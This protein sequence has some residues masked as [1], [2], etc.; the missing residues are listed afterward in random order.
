MARIFVSS[1]Y[2]DLKECREQICLILR[3]AGHE[4]L[5]MEY[6][7]TRENHLVDR[8]LSDVASSDLYVGIFAWRYG[9]IPQQDNPNQLSITELEY[10]QA[11]RA[12]KECL[13]FLLH[14]DAPW[15]RKYIDT[16]GR[17]DQ[18]R[19]EL[20]AN[21]RCAYFNSAQEISS[22]AGPAIHQWASQRGLVSSGLSIQE[23]DLETYY[24]ALRKRYQRLDLEGLTP[25]QKEE[26]LQ[27]QLRLVF[28][29]QSVREDPP[30]IELSKEVWEKLHRE[31]EIHREDF[32]I[33]MAIDDIRRVRDTYYEKPVQSVLDVLTDTRSNRVIILGDPGSGKS[34]LARY[35]LLSLLD[36]SGN[37]KLNTAFAGYVPFLI[38]LRSYAGLRAE[39]KCQ[40]FL[41]F[42]ENR[43]REEGWHI[44]EAMLRQY[45]KNNKKALV[46]LDGLDE[47]FDP[48]DRERI[49][50]QI[51]EFA[52]D[53]PDSHILATSRI[54]GYRRKILADA[55]FVH[56]TLQ[57]LNESQVDQFV[58]G[59]YEL[60][61]RDR[62]LEAKDR[63]ERILRSFRQ[64]PSIRQLAGNPMLLTIMAII[65]KHQELPRERWKLYDHAA[66]VL[67]E[68]WDVNK[69][70]DEQNIH[71]E[72]ISEEDK[73]EMLRRLAYRM[74]AG[75]GGLAGNY[76]P[77]EELQAEFEGYL[78]DRYNQLPDRAKIVAQAILNQLRERN[79][80]LSLFGAN[81]YGFV[82]RAFLEYFCATAIVQKF[83]KTQEIT[84]AQ[85]KQDIYGKHLED[86]SW[87]EVL[88]L[89][90]G[91]VDERF[92]GVIIEYL[93]GDQHLRRDKQ[94][95]VSSY[96][97]ITLA[98]QCMGEV[99]SLS[100]VARPARYLLKVICFLFE[101]HQIFY[102]QY[103]ILK[104]HIAAAVEIIGPNWPH[105]DDLIDWLRG[106][107]PPEHAF[108]FEGT[109]GIII[110]S[111]GSGLA[112]VHQIVLNYLTSS[113]PLY[114]KLAAHIVI[115]GWR[116]DP[117]T[118]PLL[119]DRA[120]NDSSGDVRGSAAE[121]LAEHFRDDPKVLPLLLDRAANDSG[122][123]IRGSAVSALAEH[124]RDGPK[125]LPLL[126][127]RAANDPVGEV[128]DR[129]VRALVRI[130]P[131]DAR[132][133]SLL[134]DLSQNAPVES[135]RILAISEL[136]RGWP[137]D[138]HALPLLDKL[139][140]LGQP[141][142]V[143]QAAS[144]KL[145]IRKRQVLGWSCWLNGSWGEADYATLPLVNEEQII[146]LV[147]SVRLRNI[148]V[149]TDTGELHFDQG[150]GATFRPMTLLL[151]DNAAGK[152]TL[153]RCIGLASLGPDLANQLEKRPESYLRHGA[154][155]GYIEVMFQLQLFPHIEPKSLGTF[156]I[157]LEIRAGENSFRAIEN[158]DLSL[159]QY[160][161]ALRLN[162]LRIRTEDKFGFVCG[163]GALRSLA[164]NPSLPQ[165]EESKEVLDRV[166]SLFR[167][168][169]PVMDPD[170]LGRLLAG[171]LSY[172]RSAPVKRLD[173]EV[174][175][176]MAAHIR[177]LM[178]DLGEVSPLQSSVVPVGGTPIA[179]SDLS[180]GYGSLLALI[181]H[182]IRHI[183][184]ARNW[185]VDPAE[186]FGILLIDEIDL[187]L[188]PAW[189]RR[190]VLDLCRVFPRLQ[191][192]GTSHSAMVA[193]SVETDSIVVLRRTE[194]QVCVITDIPSVEGWR[195]DQ[196]LT[197]LLFDLPTTRN[198][199]TEMLLS[200]YATLLT[201]RG[202][203]DIEV[204]DLGKRVSQALNMEGDGVV[205]KYTHQLLDELLRKRFAFL[206][207]ELQNQ[208][209]AKAEL[210]LS[211]GKEQ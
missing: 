162:S 47:I 148:R 202:P 38:E 155:R 39:G 175:Q 32:P 199:E 13:I 81:L 61:L 42:L 12:G 140:S 91:L 44:T 83:E 209:L 107:D 135:T 74:Q 193:G 78:R 4:D 184:S 52:S 56:F 154:D 185:K 138:P 161:A 172:F 110:G 63:R 188:H 75:A 82:H 86:Q 29:E 76:I 183:L 105:R 51:V 22:V 92:A 126:L 100:V 8:R 65:G 191:I 187:H 68:H 190:V 152:S 94:L 114:R 40:S 136:T 201:E 46:I 141:E 165:P 158:A 27:L 23:F 164:D 90:C 170:V 204:R 99:R 103:Q 137:D 73:K 17:I 186:V 197:S 109:L 131:R 192:I 195:A 41:E 102:E 25:P 142:L 85:L 80:I 14:E 174:Q 113:N 71:A 96:W 118:L 182:L 208:V 124:F 11:L 133:L 88:R 28:V 160:N 33:G 3:R 111:V 54:I 50:S 48:E 21:H 179:L 147:S 45:L 166:V 173:E 30:P 144:A 6:Y 49:T 134:Y 120:A 20:I 64:S 146:V 70:L 121:V 98:V 176:R 79:F 77:R 10:R 55:G 143:R 37:E 211:N 132:V 168:T 145:H 139:A 207:S 151:G 31:R 89:I 69:H 36:A 67:I 203:E 129:A 58:S 106:Y 125:V 178:P 189:Q 200:K 26:Y 128:C 9:W 127:D 19:N 7:A 119:L 59:W 1:T 97:G 198:V 122:E 149:F 206:N 112:D 16:D 180:D 66:S 43:G 53:Y 177:A 123:Y 163:Y 210:L 34:T 171:D 35:V 104:N 72:F 62:P 159:S 205:D 95:P 181:G 18:L 196:I 156:C 2:L 93:A 157:G 169:A 15:P 130:L 115:N 5:S 167:S 108:I 117:L 116:D 150:E 87:H 57:D 60:A 194:D 24:A 153:L 101:A 84:L